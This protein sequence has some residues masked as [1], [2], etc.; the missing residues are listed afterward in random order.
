MSLTIA[1]QD[2]YLKKLRSVTNYLCFFPSFHF[3][4]K[5]FLKN[6]FLICVCIV[7]SEFKENSFCIFSWQ[8]MVKFSPEKEWLGWWDFVGM[9]HAV[10]SAGGKELGRSNTYQ[11]VLS[12]NVYS[13]GTC[14]HVLARL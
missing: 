14:V 5:S 12:R 11:S 2:F 13:I 4:G 6:C 7:V 1:M 10:L 9:H 8:L 3:K